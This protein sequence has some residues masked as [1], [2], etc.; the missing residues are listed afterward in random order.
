MDRSS[1]GDDMN[2][3][4]RN[5]DIGRNPRVDDM[6]GSTGGSQLDIGDAIRKQSF[7]KAP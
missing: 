3:S 2:S 6:N 1:R 4:P 5:D 7:H